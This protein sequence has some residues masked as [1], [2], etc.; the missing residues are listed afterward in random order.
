MVQETRDISLVKTM[1]TFWTLQSVARFYLVML[2]QE[3]KTK[4]ESLPQGNV[5]LFVSLL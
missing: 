3:I 4:I 2:P 1:T 5:F